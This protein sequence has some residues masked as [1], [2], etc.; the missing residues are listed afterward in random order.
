M[1]SLRSC[2]RWR[3]NTALFRRQL[4]ANQRPGGGQ[5]LQRV[6]PLRQRASF[7]FAKSVLLDTSE[8][9]ELSHRMYVEASSMAKSN[10]I[11]ETPHGASIQKT[12]DGQFMV[13][14]GENN[15]RITRTLY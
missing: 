15:C 6:L 4:F 8:R 10:L 2:D 13:C 5:R 7:L 3:M 9:A 11:V 1:E 14:D 12:E